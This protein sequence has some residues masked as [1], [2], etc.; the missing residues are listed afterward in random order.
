M[1]LERALR[2]EDERQNIESKGAEG[3]GGQHRHGGREHS[4]GRDTNGSER[5]QFKSFS[6]GGHHDIQASEQRRRRGENWKL[7]KCP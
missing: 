4:R 5:C 1:F 2:W 3:Q 6:V 7:K